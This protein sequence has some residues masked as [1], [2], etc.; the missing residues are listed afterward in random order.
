MASKTDDV[1][2]SIAMETMAR[3]QRS[4]QATGCYF[5]IDDEYL[6]R[7]GKKAVLKVR[8]TLTLFVLDPQVLSC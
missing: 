7:T 2:D 4:E 1:Q 6:N 3:E 8:T 5:N